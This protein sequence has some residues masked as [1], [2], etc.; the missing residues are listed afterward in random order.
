VGGVI[1]LLKATKDKYMPPTVI[2]TQQTHEFQ[3]H[4]NVLLDTVV[5][6]ALSR[7]QTYKGIIPREYDTIVDNLDKLIGI[8]VSINEGKIESYYPFRATTYVT[9][10]QTALNHAKSKIRNVAV[11]H[12]DVDETSI[13]QIADDYL[14]NITQDVNQN[15]LSY[16]SPPL[17]IRK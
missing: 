3:R 1:G 11:P 4:P 6:E 17:S 16:R 10:I 13:R 15:M 5:M 8:Q 7:F 9:N 14:Y 2:N 12:W